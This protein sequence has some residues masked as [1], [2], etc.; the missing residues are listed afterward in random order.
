MLTYFSLFALKSFVHQFVNCAFNSDVS[1]S[2]HRMHFRVAFLSVIK[3][4]RVFFLAGV[5]E[6]YKK[7]NEDV[8]EYN[9]NLV[10]ARQLYFQM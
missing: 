9:K 1:H 5:C 8:S 10:N 3:T 2:F 7:E 6:S 4:N